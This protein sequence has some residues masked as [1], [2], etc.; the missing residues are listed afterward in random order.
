MDTLAE[1]VNE[2]NLDLS[3]QNSRK[4]FTCI[5]QQCN[6]NKKWVGLH[7]LKISSGKEL[8]F[9]KFLPKKK[10]IIIIKDTLS[11]MCWGQGVQTEDGVFLKHS[12]FYKLNLLSK[13]ILKLMHKC[14][15]TRQWMGLTGEWQLSG[16]I[17][18]HHGNCMVYRRQTFKD[19][20]SWESK[21]RALRPEEQ[22]T[23]QESE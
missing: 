5:S 8:E 4:S 15:T 20:S 18:C 22:D 23:S 14:R 9:V 17:V 10:L 11:F 21:C 19:R 12:T 16:M 1:F 7:P 2:P 6:S 3:S 13:N